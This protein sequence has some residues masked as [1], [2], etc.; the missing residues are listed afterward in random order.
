MKDGVV[1]Q[2]PA[3]GAGARSL[4]RAGGLRR[5]APSS[6]GDAV[7]RAHGRRDRRR[8]RGRPD[9]PWPRRHLQRLDARAVGA[10]PA[11]DR[12]PGPAGLRPLAP[13]RGA[14]VDRAVRPGDGA[15]LR[16]AA[17]SRACTWRRI[18]SARSS[19]STSR[20]RHR[21]WCRAWRSSARCCARPTPARPGLRARGEKARGEGEAGMQAIADQL[22]Q[23]AISTETRT[24]RPVAVTAVREL[25]M[26]QC[27]DG[28][29]R[30]CEALA[31]ARAAEVGGI[32]CPDDAGDGRRGRDRPR[33]GRAAD[34]RAHRATPASPC[35]R[36]AATG[37][38]SRSPR[39]ATTCCGA[40]T[41]GGCRRSEPCS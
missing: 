24:R 38:W 29:A 41:P 26:R 25:V 20:W 9:D 18:R 32:A 40:S 30:T 14:A 23:G 2:G 33:P 19:R 17:G 7:H 27:P 34:R 3:E 36:V 35:C 10:G 6:R 31:D 4:E 39:S 5:E 15:R 16:R 8:R 1:S 28:Y 22:V 13:G 21:G 11:P 12:A 37:P